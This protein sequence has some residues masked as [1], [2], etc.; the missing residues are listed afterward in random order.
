[1]NAERLH[2]IA[3]AV[4]DDLDAIEELPLLRQLAESLRNQVNDP[5]QPD[6]GVQTGNTRGILVARLTDDA[7]SN[8]FSA[9]WHEALEDLGIDH[10]LGA[11]LRERIDEI[12]L[13]NEITV[14]VAADEIAALADEVENLRNNLDQMIAGFVGFGIGAEELD[15]GEFEIGCLIPRDAPRVKNELGGLGKELVTIKNEILGPIQEMATG[16][17]GDLK[18]SVISSSDFQIFIETAP[19]V[20]VLLSQILSDLLAAYERIRQLRKDIADMLGRGVPEDALEGVRAHA[21]GAME[22]DVTRLANQLIADHGER[23]AAAGR[24]P[25]ETRLFVEHSLRETARRIDE[26]WT[27]EVR[28]YPEP[29]EVGEGE[30]PLPITEATEQARR[31]IEARQPAMRRMSLEGGPILELEAAD[32]EDEEPAE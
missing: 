29:R 30:E 26:R 7:P 5:A 11:A 32:A 23:L 12:F 9:S 17:R 13:R 28:S 31:T 15:P 4:R 22:L 1:M 6:H 10:L 14:A 19:E 16:G 25:D 20:A 24:T 27:F 2:A 18:I 3:R 8:T 21:N